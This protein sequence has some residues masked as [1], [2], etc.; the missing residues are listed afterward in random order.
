MTITTATNNNKN[1]NIT[2]PTKETTTNNSDRP[3]SR[4][5]RILHSHPALINSLSG[6]ATG[7]IVSVTL[8]PFDVIKTRLTVQRS[9]M[10]MDPQHKQFNGFF[11]AYSKHIA[12]LSNYCR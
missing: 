5:S 3:R 10:D 6:A 2:M 1:N 4:F 7:I 12:T 9:H 11:S 8:S